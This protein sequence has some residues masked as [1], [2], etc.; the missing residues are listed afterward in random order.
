ML[1]PEKLKLVKNSIYRPL[2]KTLSLYSKSNYNFTCPKFFGQFNAKIFQVFLFFSR[3]YILEVRL[4]NSSSVFPTSKYMMSINSH[5]S[6][7]ENF[8]NLKAT[9]TFKKRISIILCALLPW[10]RETIKTI[11]PMNSGLVHW[12]FNE[13]ATNHGD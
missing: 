9:K 5:S 3:L 7:N 8:K 12:C 13:L 4:R 11:K 2:F 10:K 1:L 6:H